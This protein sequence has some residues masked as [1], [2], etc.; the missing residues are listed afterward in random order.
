MEPLTNS[1]N[2]EQEKSF[3]KM[4]EQ[5]PVAMAL[6][7]GENFVVTMANNKQFELWQRQPTEVIDK[8]L[9]DILPEVESQPFKQLLTEVY[10][11]G[12]PYKAEDMAAQFIRNGTFETAWFDFVYQPMFDGAG[13]VE[14]IMVVS[15]EVTDKILAR[16]K[17]EDNEARLQ[18][19]QSELEL[20]IE[21]GAVGIWHLDIINNVLRWNKKQHELYGVNEGEFG[22]RAEDF[23]R[24]IFPEDL[25]AMMRDVPNISPQSPY[26][27]YN[28]R[29]RR[30]DGS[31]RWIYSRSKT[32][33]SK[34]GEPQV[35]TGINVDVTERKQQEEELRLYEKVVASINEAVLVSKVGP[36]DAV[37][38]PEIL[39]VNEAFT[40]ITG[41]SLNDVAGKTY[42][43][44]RGDETEPEELEKISH[45][46]A[47]LQPVK[48][49]FRA[50]RKNG[51][52]FDV[53]L[54]VT[55][56]VD[57]T[58]HHTH[59]IF[60]L[61]DVTRR[62]EEEQRLRTSEA[63]SRAVLESSPDCIK[64][65]DSEGRLLYMNQNGLC[66]MEINDFCQVKEKLWWDL[67]P[68][69]SRAAIKAA[70]QNGFLGQTAQVQAFCPTA[71]GT[72]KWWDVKVSPLRDHAGTVIQIIS[73]SRDITASKKAEK[74]LL[75]AQER[76]RLATE[77]T[78]LG[79]WEWDVRKGTIR[80]D[81]QMF[82]IYGVPPT[83]D[84]IVPYTT[85]SSAVVHEELAAQEAALQQVIEQK[86]HGRRS[87]RIRRL[88]DGEERSI[89]AVET[90]RL[91]AD[92]NVVYVIGTNVDVTKQMRADQELENIY[93]TAPIGLGLVDRDLRFQR[94]NDK[95]AEIN[96]MSVA[97]HLGRTIQE[98]VPDLAHQIEA[99]FQSIFNTGEAI[100]NVEVVGETRA[101][102]GV[103]RVW[104]ESWYPI[105]DDQGNTFAVSLVVE[106]VTE[107]KKVDQRIRDSENRFR[108]LAESL[109]QMVWL[110][111]VDGSLEYASKKWEDYSGIS[112]AQEAWSTM[113]HPA[114]R[115]AVHAAWEKD[116]AAG[117]AFGYEVRLRNRQ[118]QYRWHYSVAEPI[119]DEAGKIQKWVGVLIDIHEQKAFAEV[120]EAEVKQRTQE[121]QRSNNDLQ[122]FAHVASHDLKEPV[123]KVLTFAS[124]LKSELEGANSEKS[125]LF[126][127]K[128]VAAAN[129]SSDMIDG[130]LRYSMLSVPQD[131]IEQVDL[132][133]LLQSIA[134]D[135]EVPIAASG[136][137]L[138]VS[139]LPVIE[140]LKPLLY[141]L[142][143]NLVSNALKFARENVPPHITIECFEATETER[144]QRR[145]PDGRFYCI[146]V[147]DNGIGFDQQYAQRIFNT[148]TRLNSKDRYEGTGLGLALCQ[149]IVERHSGTIEAESSEGEGAIFR[150]YLPAGNADLN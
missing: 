83:S 145:L 140:G 147:R 146:S 102:P 136:A 75:E 62:N 57:E 79:I 17:L 137:T 104:N 106:E 53:E 7:W 85:W 81:R 42:L 115:D 34:N 90:V 95:L 60:V 84:G 38:G 32:I 150:V 65:L 109:P 78:E 103:Q 4:I 126:L 49:G 21:A 25:Q 133:A 123:R 41:Y 70:V 61:R 22:G 108:I 74:E 117:L 89:V 56:M 69:E 80:W 87:F 23:H 122:Q 141:Q 119:K 86:G 58:G 142:F 30:K 143:Y 92:G 63:F 148:F 113:I 135:L 6:L 51:S 129:R 128:I 111:D 37:E 54:E 68:E 59:W 101:Q 33:F 16:T 114:D 66:V 97:E 29:I 48:A 76:M 43:V 96:G 64:V 14:G 27:E 35:V 120:L 9:F 82:S 52:P 24:F 47:A 8:P 18:Q 71:K 26:T 139:R 44:L 45:A 15:T 121:L 67:W 124:L 125:K 116:F 20:S 144:Q 149:K 100:L 39:Y 1:V 105:K 36:A 91:D 94:I 110:I 134:A 31:V 127:D 46:L 131:G 50:C 5:A 12:Q 13:K 118:G 138:A 132:S 40:G 73:V 112:N 107:R 130:V 3:Y 28:F 2:L 10:Q 72:P 98:V 19:L 93:R 88:S 99:L 77:A 11:T 55:P